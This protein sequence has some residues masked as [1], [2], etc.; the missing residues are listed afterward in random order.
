MSSVS[1]ARIAVAASVVSAALLGS[2]S[3]GVSGASTRLASAAATPPKT[4][5]AVR[6]TRRPGTLAPGTRVSSASL[7][8]QR[9]F[10][11]ANHGFALASPSEADYAVAT[12]DGGK[13]W[14]TDGPALH[15]HAAQAPLA[16][17]YIGAVNRKTVFAWGGGQVIDTTRDGGK[18]WY[19]ALFTDGGPVA[20]V[21]EPGGHLLAFVGSFSGTPT[22][23]YVSRDGGRTWH[24]Q[25]TVGR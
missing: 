1:S 10:T 6:L 9:V 21:P 11:D 3:V 16:V 13:T 4:V 15:L 24:Y 23:Q 17:V 25:T 5:T 22:W 12:T 7:F 14:R 8:G 2:S 20:V 18:S 19:S